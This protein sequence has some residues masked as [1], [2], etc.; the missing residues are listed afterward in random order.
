MKTFLEKFFVGR[1]EFNDER[2][3]EKNFGGTSILLLLH[4]LT[5]NINLR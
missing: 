5:R 1:G 4:T 2:K 3:K